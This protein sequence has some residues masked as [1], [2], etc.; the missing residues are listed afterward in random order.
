MSSHD[1]NPSYFKHFA[2]ETPCPGSRLWNDS[3]RRAQWEEKQLKEIFEAKDVSDAI[4]LLR[5]KGYIIS[6]ENA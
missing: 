2:S 5:S 4:E 3:E 6:K 1:R